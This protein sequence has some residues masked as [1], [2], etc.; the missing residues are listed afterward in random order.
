MKD[1]VEGGKNVYGFDIGI[2]M[3]ETRFPRILGDIGN[4]K[5]FSYPVLY[6]IVKGYKPDKVVLD[7]K[8]E[9][10]RPFIDSAK[11]LEDMG[12]KAIT[13]SCGFLAMFQSEI[14]SCIKIP[15]FTSTIVLLP[16]LCKMCGGMKVLVLTAN[17]ET[18]TEK[19]FV[20]ACGSDYTKYNFDVV[21]TQ[22]MKTFTNFTVQNRER[23]SVRE[24]GNDIM[25][26]VGQAFSKQKYG[27]VLMECTNIPP[28]SDAV[29]EK[30]KVPVF[31]IVTLTNFLYIAVNRNG[32][33]I[34]NGED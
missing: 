7:L 26:T 15:I 1:I 13:T 27:A 24:C 2:I 10:I 18:L 20:S 12:V 25:N 32:F 17:S 31:D 22:T 4:A 30:Y 14:A 6:D 19:H 33:G 34:F 8:M 11:R 23:V 9:D 28:Y 16:L 29:R 5:T 3:L 21:G